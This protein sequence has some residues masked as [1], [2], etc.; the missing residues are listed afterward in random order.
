M[1]N[2]LNM[3][4]IMCFLLEDTS[5]LKCDWEQA[6]PDIHTIGLYKACQPL[7]NVTPIAFF[8][9]KCTFVS[10]EVKSKVI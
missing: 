2:G 10:L 3:F 6:Q 8:D 4:Q 5:V 7:V 1:A 9:V